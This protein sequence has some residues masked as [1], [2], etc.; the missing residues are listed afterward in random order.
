M[1]DLIFRTSDCGFINEDA[2]MDN[3]GNVINLD[4][5]T[6]YFR[7]V[8]QE[9]NPFCYTFAKAFPSLRFLLKEEGKEDIIKA[10]LRDYY[11][12]KDDCPSLGG[13]GWISY[14]EIDFDED[15]DYEFDYDFDGHEF[16][17]QVWL[18]KRDE[19]LY[20]TQAK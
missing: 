3:E 5:I 12:R 14:M 15:N 2:E 6:D 7:S 8:M 11:T 16:K 18:Q 9:D 13:F 20:T 10:I 1:T 17:I 19:Q 4:E